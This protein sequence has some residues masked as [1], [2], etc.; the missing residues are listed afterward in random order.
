MS[1]AQKKR[2]AIPPT[3]GV[4]WTADENTLLG[5]MKDREVAEKTGRTELAVS[6][7]RYILGVPAFTKRAPQGEPF[8]WTPAKDRLLGTMPDGKLA[9][10]DAERW[11]ST[12]HHFSRLQESA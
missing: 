5:T 1:E 12:T 4:P 9:S 6:S 7:R 3:A 10:C 11:Q 8:T 2:G